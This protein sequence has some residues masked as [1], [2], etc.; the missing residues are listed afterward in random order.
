MPRW[1]AA[2]PG[3]CRATLLL[4][5]PALCCMAH[6]LFACYRCRA[7]AKVQGDHAQLLEA[8]QPAGVSATAWAACPQPGPS[9]AQQAGLANSS[10]TAGVAPFLQQ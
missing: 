8:V 6:Y 2:D 9:A 1:D 4:R 7:Q 5:A 10:G 3:Q